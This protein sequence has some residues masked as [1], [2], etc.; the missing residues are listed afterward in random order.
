M[1]GDGFV[2]SFGGPLRGLSCARAIRDELRGLGLEIRAGLHTG[3]GSVPAAGSAASCS[4]SPRGW[5]PQPPPAVFVSGT[6]KDL[7]AGSGVEFDDR[8]MHVLKGVPGGWR[9]SA[10]REAGTVPASR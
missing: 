6:V 4:T 3:R 9:L 7:V 2:A 10:V 8:G 1:V 5:R